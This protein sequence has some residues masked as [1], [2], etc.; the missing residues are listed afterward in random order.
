[1]LPLFLGCASN[2]KKIND[3]SFSEGVQLTNKTEI[4]LINGVKIVFLKDSSLPR[5]NILALVGSGSIHDPKNKAGV[6]YLTASMLDE[7]SK[8]HT[9]SEMAEH[10]ES[11][12]ASLSIQPSYDYT[13]ISMKGLSYTKEF[14]L[15]SFLEIVLTPQ[16][17]TKELERLKRQIQGTLLKM[18]DDPD[19]FTDFLFS[20]NLY[21]NHPYSR[22]TLGD[23]NS[24]KQV[25]RNDLVT[26][27][28]NYFIPKNTMFAIAGDFDD[29]FIQ[30][31]K[32]KL[33]T[34]VVDKSKSGSP[35]GPP[36]E[37]GPP[38]LYL[39]SKKGLVQSQI[40]MG[41]WFIDRS[42]PDFISLR[43]ANMALGGAFASRLNQ[44][45]RDDLGL[46]Y[47][48]HSGFD[49]RRFTGPFTI[50]T[51]TRNDKVG[52]T[53]SAAL[54]VFKEFSQKGITEEELAASKSTLIGQFPRAVETTES[55]A[56]QLLLLRYY[57]VDESYLT[58]FISNVS[59]LTLSEVN[60]R[61]KKYFTPEKLNIVIYGDGS[62]FEK[63]LSKLGS[64][65]KL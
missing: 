4:E 12:G 38:G 64:I 43:A 14:L 58:K 3:R 28:Q 62:Q 9:S 55:L 39:K 23:V 11:L 30:H 63:Q 17:E 50:E 20:K 42:H 37:M 49:A 29:L 26:H 48:I 8:N 6:A 44:R 45:V 24:V 56:Y 16:F 36:V 2:S 54:D 52:E 46:T 31:V 40:R 25:Q 1:M 13:Y 51:F 22:P 65:N 41:Q 34:W 60:A 61:V 19:Q 59:A 33:A 21:K 57:G 5:I 35:W 32:T 27:Y 18:E 53:I 15:D 47:S 7:G 10:L